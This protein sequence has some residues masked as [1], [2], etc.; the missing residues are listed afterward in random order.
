MQF[1][2]SR[3]ELLPG[4]SNLHIRDPFRFFTA[5]TKGAL[6][7]CHHPWHPLTGYVIRHLIEILL[8]RK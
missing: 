8:I 7:R 3:H 5:V 1:Y 2:C 6:L 4:H